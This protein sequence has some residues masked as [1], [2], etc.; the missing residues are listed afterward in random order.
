MNSQRGISAKAD[1]TV[2]L[3]LLI[4]N[5]YRSDRSGGLWGQDKEEGVVA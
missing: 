3:V 4:P 5:P 2:A 1:L